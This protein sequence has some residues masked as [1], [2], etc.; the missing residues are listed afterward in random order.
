M[1]NSKSIVN[2]EAKFKWISFLNANE[3]FEK[4]KGQNAAK[5]TLKSLR[6]NET[7]KR[8]S[9]KKSLKDILNMEFFL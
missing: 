3:I 6:K 1:E 5:Q 4:T 7:G 9:Y 8:Y 2:S